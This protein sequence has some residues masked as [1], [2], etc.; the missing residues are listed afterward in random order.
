MI[1]AYQFGTVLIQIKDGRILFYR[2]LP[3]VAIRQRI[4]VGL[5]NFY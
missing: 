5:F 1:I 3:C 4:Q 2:F